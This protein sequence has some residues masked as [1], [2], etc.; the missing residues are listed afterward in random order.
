MSWPS[1]SIGRVKALLAVLLLV[2]VEAGLM[3]VVSGWNK[4]IEPLGILIFY[5]TVL[6]AFP[7]LVYDGLA[8]IREFY[9]RAIEERSFRGL[10]RCWHVLG[11]VGLWLFF[12]CLFTFGSSG[13]MSDTSLLRDVVRCVWLASIV[14]VVVSTALLCVDVVASS[15]KR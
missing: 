10:A 8:G 11:M 9:V 12:T 13:G 6:A 3:S 14:L 15:L 4:K 7:L 5:G 1:L 2:G